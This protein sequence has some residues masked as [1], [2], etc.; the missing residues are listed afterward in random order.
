MSSSKLS[1]GLSSRDSSVFQSAD[2]EL[3]LG[4]ADL[5]RAFGFVQLF[6]SFIYVATNHE[7]ISLIL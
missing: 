2:R 1:T 4:T 3:L 7:T 6:A 5:F